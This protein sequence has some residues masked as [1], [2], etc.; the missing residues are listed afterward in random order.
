[1]LLMPGRKTFS[2]LGRYSALNERTYRRQFR[3]DFDFE[4]FNQACIERQLGTNRRLAAVIDASYVPKSGKHTFGLDLFY[5]STAGKA[6]R[7]LEISEI[8]LV[9]LDSAQAY[10]LS[11]RQTKARVEGEEVAMR[12]EQYGQHLKDTHP[13]FPAGV[14]LVLFD[15]YYAKRNFVDEVCALGLHGVGKLRIDADLRYLYRGPYRG[16]GR[17]KRYDGKVDV[18]DLSQM[19]YEGE[20]EHDQ[21]LFTAVVWS[22]ALKRVIR[23]ALI[24]DS[25]TGKPRRALLFST[26]PLLSA[27]E[28]VRLYKLRFQ[29]EFLIRDS[30]QF[31]GLTDCQ[32][33][34]EQAL[35]FHFN[36]AFAAVNLAKLQ[37]Q[38][39]QDPKEPFVFSLQS[40]KR[41]LFNEHLLDCFFTA[42]GLDLTWLKSHP[43]YLDLV[44]YGSLAA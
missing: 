42:L 30:K 14:A 28:V 9:D 35:A 1:M 25:S 41:Q 6:R 11:C 24:L 33:R 12:P 40:F 18:T 10:G 19:V 8:A 37:L 22:C 32:A 27:R 43:A 16:R 36:T 44:Q 15:G 31:T 4:A 23:L 20:L 5:S 21:H 38:Q 34:A 13:H 26:D 29:V 7:G 2:N 39:T 3:S 17:P